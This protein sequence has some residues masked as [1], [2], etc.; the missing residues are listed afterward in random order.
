MNNI[1]SV[2]FVC[3]GNSCRSIMA[4]GLLKK[5]LKELGKENIEVR[6]AG[7]IALPERAPTPE[8]IEVMGEEG[9]DVSGYSSKSLTRDLIKNS[10]LILVMEKMHA[11]AVANMAPEAVPKTFLLKEFG[12]RIDDQNDTDVRDPIGM[13][14]DEY[15]DCLDTVK[16]H[17]ERIA[18][19]L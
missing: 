1:S 9:L 3:T 2:L 18:K 7:I 5:Y 17:I 6:S 4:E 16:R 12:G 8:T 15:R 14:L 11:D 13:P 19:K 10:D